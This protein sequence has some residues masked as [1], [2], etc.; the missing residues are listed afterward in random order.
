MSRSH[1]A[2]FRPSWR[3]S[4]PQSRHSALPRS[5]LTPT[6]SGSH[7]QMTAAFTISPLFHSPSP[8]F[9]SAFY[10]SVVIS[11][12]I[13]Q[14]TRRA[15]DSPPPLFPCQL[16]SKSFRPKLLRTLC[17]LSH[18]TARSKPCVFSCLRTL[19]RR[20]GRGGGLPRI[21]L[22]PAVV[23]PCFAFD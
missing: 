15:S 12:M 16:S 1:V 11:H 3:P 5:P 6:G 7:V 17:A 19:C 21:S 14:A 2:V 18:A 4:V 23:L 13:R 10:S 9:T 8:K 22:E 20:N